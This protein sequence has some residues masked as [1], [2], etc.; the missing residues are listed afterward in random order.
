[1]KNV[2]IT[3]G[4]GGIGSYL[5]KHLLEHNY[6]IIVI[7]RK[8]SR[9]E[10]LP[11]DN[12]NIRFFSLDI[13]SS[14]DVVSFYKWYSDLN[15]SIFALI[16]AAGIQAPI[17]EFENNNYQEWENNLNT[18]IFGTANMIRGAIPLL[19]NGKH[20]KIINFSGGGATSFRP[21]FSAYAL[22]KIGI[23]KLTEI[24]ANEL[25]KY[26]IDVNAVAPGA[27][28]TDMLN[29][30]LQAGDCAGVEYNDAI[31]R[32]KEG[33]DSPDKIVELCDFLLSDKSSGISGKLISAIWDDF[34]SE[35]FINRLKNDPNFC[36]LRRIDSNNFDKTN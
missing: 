32:Q 19:K 9:F 12:P 8:K 5:T 7:G 4:A 21:N 18:N 33:G 27:I 30:I 11:F 15:N 28:N 1:M 34:K 26:S 3:G 23:V 20:N 10:I 14:N 35:Q 13:S 17:G 22:S 24:L 16:N 31:K 29:E 6:S 25:N 36:T 2:I